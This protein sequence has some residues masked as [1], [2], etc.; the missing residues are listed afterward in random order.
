M[1]KL[2]LGATFLTRL[3]LVEFIPASSEKGQEF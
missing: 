3:G 2:I 1:L